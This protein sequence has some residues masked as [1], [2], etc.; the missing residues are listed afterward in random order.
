MYKFMYLYLFMKCLKQLHAARQ[1]IVEG[2]KLRPADIKNSVH[3]T[4]QHSTAQRMTARRSVIH[5]SSCPSSV[6]VTVH[7]EKKKPKLIQTGKSFWHHFGIFPEFRCLSQD[8]GR[9]YRN[10]R[11]K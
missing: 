3:S 5:P 8:P 1:N 9:F 11:S 4:A 7:Q 6:L 2:H 10:W